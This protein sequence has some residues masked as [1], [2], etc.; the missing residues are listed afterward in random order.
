MASDLHQRA[1]TGCLAL[2][3]R[4]GGEGAR[5]ASKTAS[6]HAHSR[7]LF[8]RAC[9]LRSYHGHSRTIRTWLLR[10]IRP[11]AGGRSQSLWAPTTLPAEVRGAP[12]ARGAAS[13]PSLLRA[14]PQGTWGAVPSRGGRGAYGGSEE[15][16]SREEG[17]C[18]HGPSLAGTASSRPTP[19]EAAHEG[20][21]LRASAHGVLA[22]FQAGT[23]WGVC[24]W[25]IPSAVCA[26]AWACP[27]G[28]PAPMACQRGPPSRPGEATVRSRQS[29]PS[30]LLQM[31]R[32]LPE[33]ALCW[34]D[35]SG[36]LWRPPPCPLAPPWSPW[37]Q[38]QLLRHL[39]GPEDVYPPVED[40][41]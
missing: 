16:P 26:W 31:S 17:A 29:H 14:V 5:V 3:T 11:R 30:C 24:A 10:G 38:G 36:V 27:L 2:G 4:P 41:A 33:I 20:Q 7:A 8:V 32:Q 40:P 13:G 37:K 21:G 18:G 9:F 1:S 6:L 22:P 34:G 12:R 25:G 35:P 39:W 19:S 15:G 23:L 28:V